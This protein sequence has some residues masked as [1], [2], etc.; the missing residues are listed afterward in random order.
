MSA[1]HKTAGYYKELAF[2]KGMEWIEDEMGGVYLRQ[3]G[4]KAV[5][6]VGPVGPLLSVH[7]AEAIIDRMS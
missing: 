2:Y 7:Q 5:V 1:K 4:R 3:I 6:Q